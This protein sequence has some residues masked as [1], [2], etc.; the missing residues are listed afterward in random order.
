[1]TAPT[2]EPVSQETLE[3]MAA[4]GWPVAAQ[5]IAAELLSSRAV[6]R[7]VVE[8]IDAQRAST[9]NRRLP[10]KPEREAIQARAK[11]SE[12]ALRAHVAKTWGEK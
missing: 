6:M 3:R 7:E 8:A 11:Q 2:W 9:A 12:A 4:Q 5:A 10:G 1:M